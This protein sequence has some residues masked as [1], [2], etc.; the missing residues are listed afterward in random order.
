MAGYT[1][2]EDDDSLDRGGGLVHPSVKLVAPA[3]PE[4]NFSR[5]GNVWG[6]KAGSVHFALV[7]VPSVLDMVLWLHKLY[8]MYVTRKFCCIDQHQKAVRADLSSLTAS[9]D[10]RNRCQDQAAVAMGA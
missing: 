3:R 1:V 9:I 5:A 10:A 4:E 6:S 7:T 8:S 2:V